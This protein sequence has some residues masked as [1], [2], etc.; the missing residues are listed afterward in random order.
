M[1]YFFF[2]TITKLYVSL[3]T[4]GGS[5]ATMEKPQLLLSRVKNSLFVGW[6]SYARFLEIWLPHSNDVV[7]LHNSLFLIYFLTVMP[8][9]WLQATWHFSP[10]I[11]A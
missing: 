11:E 10:S 2:L 9:S 7:N 4:Q 8:T 3:I 5:R 1:F 6:Q